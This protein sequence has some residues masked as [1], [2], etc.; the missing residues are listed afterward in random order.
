MN[1]LQQN[2]SYSKTK[3]TRA[4]SNVQGA[5]QYQYEKITVVGLGLMGTLLSVSFANN[6]HQVIA[7]DMD[8]RKVNCVNQN[9][10]PIQ[11][12]ELQIAIRN[13]RFK[14]NL[15]ATGDMHHAVLKTDVSLVCIGQSQTSETVK[16]NKQLEAVCQQIGASLAS[17]GKYHL[18][19]VHSHLA[20]TTCESLVLP[21][22]ENWSNKRCGSDFGLCYLPLHVAHKSQHSP[23]KL[24]D[25]ILHGAYDN[26]S[27]K[28][29][30]R[31]FATLDIGLKTVGV[32][33]S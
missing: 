16:S 21:I 29:A 22:L 25:S 24:H 23:A 32:R 1:P 28:L 27:A 4:S 10:S 12:K 18:V 6:G 13:A 3:M 33:T 2:Q 26:K 30:T 11:D 20:P 14:R 19:V 7:V 5:R 15:I 9:Q 31:L 17:K 8:G